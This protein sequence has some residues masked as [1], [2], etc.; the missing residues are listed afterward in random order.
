M[1]YTDNNIETSYKK[2]LQSY[3]DTGSEQ[4]LYEAQQFTRTL[5]EHQTSPEEL[6]SL[7]RSIMDQLYPDLPE[8]IQASFD[9]LLEAMMGYGMAYREHQILRDRQQEL[10]AEIDVAAK[11]QQTLLPREELSVEGL[12]VGVV[13]VPAKKM[14]GDYYHY[15]TDQFGGVGLSISDIIG[16]GVPAA[17][18]MSMIKYAMDS[19]PEQ[20]LNP[21]ALLESLNRVVEQNVDDSMFVTMMYGYY[22]SKSHEFTYSGAGHEP[23]FFYCAQK[24][25]FEDLS[26]KGLVLGVSRKATYREYVKQLS[27]GDF[28]VFL[29]DGVTECRV[30]DEFFEREEIVTMLRKSIHLSAQEIV[31]NVYR[32]LSKLQDFSLRDDLTLIILR[33]NV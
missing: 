12:D 31:E 2:I 15:V 19:L 11:M 22:D 23:G 1:N 26:A 21:S 7:H 4:V 16:K 32:E 33:R 29:T 6:V 8:D 10:E 13:S 20:Q 30:G 18:C 14:S 25:S 17:L 28:I 27:V 3:L 24:D 9:F 5:L